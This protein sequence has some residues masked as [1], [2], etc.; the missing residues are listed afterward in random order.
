MECPGK[1][2]RSSKEK[3]DF[4]DDDLEGSTQPHDDTVVVTLQIRDSLSK[5]L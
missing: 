1:K 4:N 5:G 2:P 3:I